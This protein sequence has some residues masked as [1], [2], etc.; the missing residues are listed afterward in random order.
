MSCVSI[1][2]LLMLLMLMLLTLMLLTPTGSAVQ[3]AVG[4]GKAILQRVTVCHG[5]NARLHRLAAAG[6]RLLHEGEREA[7]GRLR[8]LFFLVI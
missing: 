2:V 6:S 7:R 4:A 3:F 1:E 8:L 5:H